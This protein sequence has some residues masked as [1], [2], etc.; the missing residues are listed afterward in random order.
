V[1]KRNAALLFQMLL[2]SYGA[3]YSPRDTTWLDYSEPE[4]VFTREGNNSG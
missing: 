4:N 3:G 1:K 2:L